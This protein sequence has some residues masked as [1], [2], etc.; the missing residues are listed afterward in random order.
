MPSPSCRTDILFKVRLEDIITRAKKAKS[1]AEA[2]NCRLPPAFSWR[3]C[4]FCF[5][6]FLNGFAWLSDGTFALFA[7]FAFLV[8]LHYS[9]YTLDARDCIIYTIY[10]VLYIIYQV[11]SMI[12]MAFVMRY[13][14]VFIVFP[15]AF[16]NSRFPTPPSEDRSHIYIYI[17]IL[18][19]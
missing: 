14:C 12:L 9:H 15:F 3:L 10:Y 18:Q 4:L 7:F 19:I 16:R 8:V 17:Y 2:P 6:F 1:H 13:L 11:S 5:L